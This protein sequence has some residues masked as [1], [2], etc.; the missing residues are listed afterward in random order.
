MSCDMLGPM[1]FSETVNFSTVSLLFLYAMITSHVLD[2]SSP[3][4][5]EYNADQRVLTSEGWSSNHRGAS[6]I[7]DFFCCYSA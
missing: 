4:H 5:S 6:E 2:M 1:K 3:F 7:W